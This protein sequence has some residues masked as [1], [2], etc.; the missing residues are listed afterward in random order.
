MNNKIFAIIIKSLNKTIYEF[1]L[2]DSLNLLKFIDKKKF[3]NLNTFIESTRKFFANT[4]FFVVTRIK[5]EIVD[6][7]AL[8]Q[9]IIKR[10]YDRKHQ[11]FY[12]KFD[13]YTFIRLHR[14]YDISSTIVLKFKYNQQYVDFFKILEKIKYL[15]Y[16][17]NLSTY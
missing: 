17:L 10:Y 14:E 5:I 6:F 12:I 3:I 9:I 13:D 16:R 2:I 1:T 11:S 7:V 15:V 4:L 8:T